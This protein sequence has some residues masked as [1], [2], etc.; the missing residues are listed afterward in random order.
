[1][2]VTTGNIAAFVESTRFKDV[3]HWVKIKVLHAF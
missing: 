2:L 1:M 3:V